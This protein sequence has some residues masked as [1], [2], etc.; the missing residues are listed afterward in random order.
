MHTGAVG[1]TTTTTTFSPG[2]SGGVAAPW[3]ALQLLFTWVAH[4]VVT[5]LPA[6]DDL[7]QL[8]DFRHVQRLL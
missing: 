7:L 5:R 3:P 1:R 4:D 2:T 8:V 6:M